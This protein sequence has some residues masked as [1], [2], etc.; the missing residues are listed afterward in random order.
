MWGARCRGYMDLLEHVQRT[1]TKITQVMEH[2]PC[3]DSLREL[4]L[5]RLAKRRLWEDLS[6]S[7]GGLF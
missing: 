3:E 4:G 5:I 2:L 6:I 7:T 1:A